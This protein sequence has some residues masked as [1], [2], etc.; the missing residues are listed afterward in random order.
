MEFRRPR[1][2]DPIDLGAHLALLEPRAACKGLFFSSVIR[3]RRAHGGTSGL[4]AIVE[5][6]YL[7]FLDYSYAD[8]LR[9]LVDTA[10]AVSP[11]G[12]VGEGA[13][14]LGRRAYSAFLG[15]NAGKVV[16]GAFSMQF[17]LVMAVAARGWEIGLNFGKVR[18]ER[19]GPNHFHVSFHGMPALLETH[20]VGVVEGAMELC[21]VRGEVLVS[22]Q[23]LSSATL[24]VR[25]G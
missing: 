25:W 13:R 14:L 15:T 6:K 10:A 1:F 2:G 4:D 20:Q 3:Q 19:A 9:L 12:S 22:V 23:S 24:D 21:G 16:F 18:S 5:R 8:Y 7:P 11:D 17:E